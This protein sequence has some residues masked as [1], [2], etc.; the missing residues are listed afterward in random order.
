MNVYDRFRQQPN[1]MDDVQ[2]LRQNPSE[3]GEMLKNSGKINEEQYQQIKG[4]SNPKDICMYLMNQ[5][6]RF[7]QAMN[8]LSNLAR[9]KK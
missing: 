9:V 5:N 6:P 7:N 3:I 4:M 2:R 1:M 8:M